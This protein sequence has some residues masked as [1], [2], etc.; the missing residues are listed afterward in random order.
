[1]IPAMPASLL[2]GAGPREGSRDTS[3]GLIV[4]ET[5]DVCLTPMGGGLVPV[6]YQ[7]WARQQDVAATADTVLQ[8]A[9]R[10]H[11]KGSL[12]LR[13]YG[14]EAGTGGGV[15]SGTTG[16]ECTPKTWSATVFAGGRNV[17]RHD[18]EWWM[19][20]GNTHGRLY[21]TKDMSEA[22]LARTADVTPLLQPVSLRSSD[23]PAATGSTEPSAG[24][25]GSG[26]SSSDA[27]S[28]QAVA[29]FDPRDNK[30]NNP[31]VTGTG[32]DR[33]ILEDA[34][35]QQLQREMDP[36]GRALRDG[37]TAGGGGGGHGGS[38]RVSGNGKIKC[39][40]I[41]NFLAKRPA[42]DRASLI[43][44]YCRQIEAQ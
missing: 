43:Q 7:I 6:P 32:T 22:P 44:E 36:I 11:V 41:T 16:A 27:G 28:S 9:M 3:E 12:V 38:V 26:G 34:E 2:A 15:L 25:P 19:N 1:M 17:V 13:C 21:Y 18:D 4:S 37:A 14:D 40:D 33:E 30:G 23:P 10:T 31:L 35:H 29:Q 5:P 24:L 39:W 20:H 42:S 8:T